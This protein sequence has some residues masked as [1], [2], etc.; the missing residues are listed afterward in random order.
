MP[1][2][3]IAATDCLAPLSRCPEIRGLLIRRSDAFISFYAKSVETA[4]LRTDLVYRLRMVVTDADE[5][6]RQG[7]P[8]TVPL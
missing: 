8:V 4:D 1:G 6:L 3:S 5:R 2:M 7:M